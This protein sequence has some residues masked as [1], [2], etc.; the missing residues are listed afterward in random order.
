M[1]R[2]YLFPLLAFS[3]FACEDPLERTE[4]ERCADKTTAYNMAA[5]FIRERHDEKM[6]FFPDR[7]LITMTSLGDCA[8][9]IKG[10]FTDATARRYEYE[11]VVRYGGDN[12]WTLEELSFE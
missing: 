3:L 2:I 8:Q 5:S 4:K 9:S 1:A 7:S 6:L 10:F 12:Y 11:A